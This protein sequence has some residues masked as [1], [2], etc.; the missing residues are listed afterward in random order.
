MKNITNNS[1][2]SYQVLFLGLFVSFLQRYLLESYQNMVSIVLLNS[3][4][5]IDMLSHFNISPMLP[6]GTRVL[7][8]FS[9]GDLCRISIQYAMYVGID[10]MDCL[11]LTPD[12]HP[13]PS[14]SRSLS[15]RIFVSPTPSPHRD[16]PVTRNSLPK[17]DLLPS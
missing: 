12:S 15:Q 3:I 17:I 11:S 10:G 14:L 7:S 4:Q 16:P 13:T 9:Q 6:S 1:L 8:I 5:N 2:M